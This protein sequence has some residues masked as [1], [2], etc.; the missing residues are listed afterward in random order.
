M[1]PNEARAS[2]ASRGTRLRS[3]EREARGARRRYARTMCLMVWVG[4]ERALTPFLLSS[5]QEPHPVS[6][7]HEIRHEPEDA[8]VRA[9]F[10]TPHVAKYGSYEGCGCGFN[11]ESLDVWGFDGPRD[12]SR[13]SARSRTKSARSTWPNKCRAIAFATPS[14]PPSPTARWRFTRVGPAPKPGAA[15]GGGRAR[16][17]LLGRVRAPPRAGALPCHRSRTAVT[18]GIGLP[19]RYP[20]IVA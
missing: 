2:V 7:Y 20:T 17:P 13:S 9:R 18:I 15:R 1:T 10:C 16:E 14:S 3:V 12:L 5:R 4:T 19:Q 8:P 6:A 11:T